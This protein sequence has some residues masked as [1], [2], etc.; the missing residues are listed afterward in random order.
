MCSLY[1]TQS[2]V[3]RRRTSGAK[4]RQG[5]ES[6]A[7]NENRALSEGSCS[8]RAITVLTVYAVYL[9]LA[10]TIEAIISCSG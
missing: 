2:V 5:G 7:K 4:A 8:V 9:E 3:L 6:A 1:R 10:A